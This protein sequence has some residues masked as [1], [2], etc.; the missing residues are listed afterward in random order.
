MP[1]ID[2]DK[3]FEH[4]R[5]KAGRVKCPVCRR[6]PMEFSDEIYGVFE[7]WQRTNMNQKIMKL[8]VALNCDN[9]GGVSFIDPM[10]AGIGIIG[11][12]EPEGKI[13]SLK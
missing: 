12:E 7:G 6:G 8:V 9:C 2:A 1:R 13:I 5:A 4:I 3:L 10:A 11:D